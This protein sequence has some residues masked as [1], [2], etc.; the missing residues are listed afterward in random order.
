MEQQILQLAGEAVTALQ[1]QAAAAG[2]TDWVGAGIGGGQ[3]LLIAYGL[4]MMKRSGDRRDRALDKQA[5]LM[6]EA[7]Q[8]LRQQGEV[9]AE[10]LRR[11]HPAKSP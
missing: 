1:V 2:R 9:L 4:W 6:T 3:L 7:V 8:G 10:L 11:P 5:E